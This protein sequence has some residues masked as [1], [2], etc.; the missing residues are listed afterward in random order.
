M[1]M[2][3]NDSGVVPRFRLDPTVN[4]GHVLT[5]VGFIVSGI[6]IWHVMDK[7]VIILEEARITQSVID[8]RQDEGISANT[9]MMREDLR[10]INNKL[11]RVIES[12]IRP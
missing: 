2:S 9:K 10:E 3:N 5:F 1:N 11:D 8:K 7:R 4:L 6:T 12:R